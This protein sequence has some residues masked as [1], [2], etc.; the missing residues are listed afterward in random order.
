MTERQAG[1]LSLEDARERVLSAYGREL[2]E[3]LVPRLRRQAKIRPEGFG[4]PVPAAGKPGKASPPVGN[5]PEGPP[6]PPRESG[7]PTRK[8]RGN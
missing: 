5:P 7:K 8:P 6:R 4:R 3:E 2:W 1:S